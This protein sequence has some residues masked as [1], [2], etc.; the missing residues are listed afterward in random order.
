MEWAEHLELART[1][2]TA[3][4]W[5]EDRGIHQ[6]AAESVWGAANLAIEAC[7]HTRGLRRH[8][9]RREKEQFIGEITVVGGPGPE[10]DVGFRLA[11]TRLHNHF[12]TNRLNAAD[13]AY[14]L[15]LGREFVTRLIEMTETYGNQ[16]GTV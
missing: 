5:L 8:G 6:L 9:N 15:G 1:Y 7:R 13:A 14:H 4:E 16:A 3:S 10:L 11:R 12:Y 2:I